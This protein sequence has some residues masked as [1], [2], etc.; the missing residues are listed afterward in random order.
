MNYIN[1]RGLVKGMAALAAASVLPAFVRAEEN[2]AAQ[3]AGAVSAAD[4][5]KTGGTAARKTL[6]IVSHPYPER[7]VLTKGL[8]QAIESMANVTVRNLESIYGFDSRAINGDT[9][10]RL[11]QEHERIVFIFPTHW[12]NLCSSFP[13]TGST[14]VH[15][16]H[17]LVQ[18]H[19]HDESLAQ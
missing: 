2:G 12:F 7:S 19:T 10:R 11:T 6:V 15:L 14:C 4:V 17:P 3:T 5:P 1:R 8:Q 16:S 13:P 9:E 18:H